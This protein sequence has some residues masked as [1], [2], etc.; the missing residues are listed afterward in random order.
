VAINEGL[1]V[2]YG[3]VYRC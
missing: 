1:V 2:F 3:Q